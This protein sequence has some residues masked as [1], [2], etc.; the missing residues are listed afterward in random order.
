MT[1]ETR[2]RALTEELPGDEAFPAEPAERTPEAEQAGEV[3]ADDAAPEPRRRRRRGARDRVTADDDE[4]GARRPARPSVPLVPVLAVLLVL[5]LGAAAWLWTTRP[6]RSPVT[7]DDYVEVLQAAR[8]AV[9][10]LTSFDHVTLD[11][12]I[13]EA[14]RVTTGDLREESVELLDSGRRQFTDAQVVVSTEVVGAG[15]TRADAERGTVV[16]FLQATQKNNA[17]EQAQVVR[18]EIEA[19]LTRVDGRWLLSGITGR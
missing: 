17:S 7:T 14:R 10:D 4:A 11:D 18:Y 8:S 5:L 12:D 1:S 16:L 13:E 6:E 19:E 3:A 15:V 2:G 9:V